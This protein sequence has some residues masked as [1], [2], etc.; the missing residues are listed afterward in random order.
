M[1]FKYV[2]NN[3]CVQHQDNTKDVPVIPSRTS[4]KFSK[5]NNHLASYYSFNFTFYWINDNIH[6]LAIYH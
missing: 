2:F 4:Q 5:P 6:A 3:W 1:Y